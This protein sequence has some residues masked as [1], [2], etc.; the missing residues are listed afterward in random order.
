[1]KGATA[2]ASASVQVQ[3]PAQNFDL[4][5]SSTTSDI[6]AVAASPTLIVAVGDHGSGASSNV[7]RTSPDGIVWT[8][9]AVAESTLNLYLECV[10]WD[11][12]RFIAGGQDYS[13]PI[14]YGVIYT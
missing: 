4:R 9:R 12:T 7:I 10:T 11:G 5:T 6:N 14:W 2:T 1:M 3:D 13:D 8:E